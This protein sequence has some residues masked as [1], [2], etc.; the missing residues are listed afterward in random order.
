MHL[1][2][3]MG[4]VLLMLVALGFGAA[5]FGKRSRLYSIATMVTSSRLVL[6]RSGCPQG[7]ARLPT[8]WA[9]AFGRE[10]ARRFAALVVVLALALLRV[11]HMQSVRDYR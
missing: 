5:A 1:V 10:S 6:D 3:G 2:F 11:Q 9:P 7:G 8:P 4:A